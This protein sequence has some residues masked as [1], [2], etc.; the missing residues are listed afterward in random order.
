MALFPRGRAR[1]YEYLNDSADKLGN[2]V[3]LQYLAFLTI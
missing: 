3:F 1:V 2:V